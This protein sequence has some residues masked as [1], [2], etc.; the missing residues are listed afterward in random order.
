[1]S[2][3]QNSDTHWNEM[4][5][6]KI[7]MVE[8]ISV[9]TKRQRARWLEESGYNPFSLKSSQVTIDLLTDSGTS[10]MS[11]DQWSA[12]M[13]GDEAYAGST[14][15]FRFEKV[16][17]DIIGFEFILPVHQGRGAERILYSNVVN[18]GDTVLSNAHF[19]TARANIANVGGYAI[20]LPAS[21]ENGSG[22]ENIFKGNM[23]VKKL[24]KMVTDPVK[25]IAL[26]V[27]TL[28]NNVVGGL[29]VSIQN[30]R[31]V[32]AV[33]KK[34]GIFLF[35]DA[36]RFAE[37]AFFIKSHEPEY[38]KSTIKEIIRDMF[39]MS[40]GCIISLKKDGLVNN[41]GILATNI[42]ELHDK[43][44][45]DLIAT[46]G[47]TTYGGLAGRDLDAIA[48]GLLE[49]TDEEYLRYR[50][51]NTAKLGEILKANGVPIIEPVGGHAVY[52][53]ACAVCPHIPE[54]QYPAWA[55]TCALFLEGGVRAVEI[56]SVMLDD[57]NHKTIRALVRLAIP[58][59][60]YT[61][62]HFEYVGRVFKRIMEGKEL[63]CGFQ[64]K[65]G[66]GK[67]RHFVAEMA[68]VC[69]GYFTDIH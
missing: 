33:C 19:D 64:L 29:P 24:E 48:V 31:E 30:L 32:N 16:A 1:M 65:K 17:R 53:D 39:S 63:I 20:D 36:C 4:E 22:A 57:H 61:I 8:P 27:V 38:Q 58:R 42:A 25:R 3:K 18:H 52:V 45:N 44:K 2:S 11:S 43:F 14:S 54:H 23:D 35:L 5:P 13:S 21:V 69:K 47:F 56:G 62:S 50:I 40:D 67:L 49:G 7:K 46:E 26:V 12:M 9:T 68:P 66:E 41:G 6:F 10:A 15:F 55:L 59:R 34:N 37:N 51:W 60:V 28:T